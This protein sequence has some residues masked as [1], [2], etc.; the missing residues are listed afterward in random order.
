MASALVSRL[1][2][3]LQCAGQV[4]S[5][6]VTPSRALSA[7]N[8]TPS[9]LNSNALSLRKVNFVEPLMLAKQEEVGRYINKMHLELFFKFFSFNFFQGVRHFGGAAPLNLDV[10][11]QRVL[12]VLRLYDKINPEKVS[13]VFAAIM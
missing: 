2:I 7:W 10:I 5:W 8:P 13:T 11:K 12:L 6:I 4:R 9:R 3:R 1:A